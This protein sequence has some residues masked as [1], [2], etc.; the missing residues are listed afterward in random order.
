MPQTIVNLTLPTVLEKIDAI[1]DAYPFYPHQQAFAA[2]DLRQRLTAYV[3]S[4]MP[5]VYVTMDAHHACNLESPGG[6]FS[7][8]Q[9][10]QLNHLVRQGIDTLLSPECPATPD[11]VLDA[12][13]PSSWFG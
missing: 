12:P 11:P 10:E 13:M 7:P 5:V 8:T 4:R 9:H 1:L 3:M 6:C 2:P